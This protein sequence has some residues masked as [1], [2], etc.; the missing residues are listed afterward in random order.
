MQDLEEIAIQK[1]QLLL[2]F[3]Y[4][5]DIILAAPTNSTNQVLKIFNSLHTRLQFTRRSGW[6]EESWE[7]DQIGLNFLD[8]III[9]ENQKIIFD[10]KK[11]RRVSG[12]F[13]NFHSQKH[14][15]C[16]K[17]GHY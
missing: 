11:P 3:R 4:I 15:L 13:L 1:L 17:K 10:T 12:R 9:V 5:N 16:H 2:Y 8:T 7:G 6:M 14:L